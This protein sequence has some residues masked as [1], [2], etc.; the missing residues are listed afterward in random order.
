[1]LKKAR[2]AFR[3]LTD[4]LEFGDGAAITELDI[5]SAF[6]TLSAD[7][8][9]IRARG[10]LLTFSVT[11]VDAVGATTSTDLD[12]RDAT[13]WDVIN[14]DGQEGGSAVTNAEDAYILQLGVSP[15]SNANFTDASVI[16]QLT[17]SVATSRTTLAFY[18][19]SKSG[20][21][22]SAFFDAGPCIMVP[23]PF[24]L[25]GGIDRIQASNTLIKGAVT[26]S[27]ANDTTFML[28][29]LAID[30]GLLPPW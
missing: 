21:N 13:D 19:A 5:S 26:N 29:V 3:R 30:S 14:E 12:V 25:P 9:L 15:S 6:A 17:T 20:A 1:M 18:N 23:M 22:R 28:R 16:Y 2:Q 10:R 11:D 24:F 7:Q 8:S 27:G 4:A